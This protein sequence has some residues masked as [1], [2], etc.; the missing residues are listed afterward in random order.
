M[1]ML[2]HL[3]GMVKSLLLAAIILLVVN[4]LLAHLVDV[5]VVLHMM[6]L[7]RALGLLIEVL[8]LV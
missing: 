4:C 1:T 8:L 6:K 7:A 3:H 5:V 2:D